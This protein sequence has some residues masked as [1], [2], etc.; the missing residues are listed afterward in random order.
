MYLGTSSGVH[1]PHSR[2]KVGVPGYI[3]C[4]RVRR[5]F[6]STRVR[7][8]VWW[9]GSAGYI[10]WAGYIYGIYAWFDPYRAYIM[11]ARADE[12][13][14]RNRLDYYSTFYA[15][16]VPLNCAHHAWILI[17]T[18]DP[19]FTQNPL[20]LPLQQLIGTKVRSSHGGRLLDM[21]T[22]IEG[23]LLWYN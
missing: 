6:T 4:K 16:S 11:H 9:N 2:A 15:T 13:T 1:V 18:A 5:P 7:Y 10:V 23:G 17:R 19:C 20:Y 8:I 22:T 12:S 14:E 21:E 3:Q